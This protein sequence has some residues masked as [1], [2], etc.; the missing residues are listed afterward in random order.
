MNSNQ[1][2]TFFD[3]VIV[4]LGGEIGIKGAWT[5][6]TYKERLISNIK[7]T[8]EHHDIS[9]DAVFRQ[10][11]RIYVKTSQALKAAQK[12]TKVFGISSLS[13][14][15]QTTSKLEDI[16]SRSL[17]LAEQRLRKHNSFAINCKR[18]GTHSYTSREVC[19]EIGQRILDLFPRLQLK[20]NLTGPDVV[21]S[22][23]VRER[24]AFIFGNII[25]ASDGLP[26]GTQPRAMVIV[27]PDENSLIAGWLVMKRGCT[28]SSIYFSIDQ[29][30]SKEAVHEVREI[31]KTL[32]RW[33]IGHSS[34]LYTIFHRQNHGI[35]KQ[36]C[37]LRL[38]EI[39]NE[40]LIYRVAA[41]IAE[42]ERT[43]AIVTGEIIGIKPHQTLRRFRLQ[44]QAISD[45]PIYR[46]LI[47]FTNA[48][49]RKLARKIGIQ[50]PKTSK[51]EKPK[52]GILPTL[53]E[54]EAAEKNLN[55]QEMI[56]TTI[57]QVEAITI[58]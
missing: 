5:R 34:K 21:I 55:I 36:R 6:R 52:E 39:I 4:R 35:L 28:V 2:E 3:T 13:P 32:S 25:P 29:N 56:N 19:V 17:N 27:K 46:P 26:V 47:G 7:A 45:Y 22:I 31:C 10:Q 30:K 8:L 14:A 37:P 23:E 15:S 48:E 53:K 33:S 42:R 43:Q 41:A 12:L 18:V 51:P 24:Q 9:Y 16:T 1:P 20:V 44:D 50:K 40:R 58:I 49:I 57:K 54:V 38:L 11:G